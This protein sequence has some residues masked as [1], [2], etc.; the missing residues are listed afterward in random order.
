MRYIVLFLS[1]CSLLLAGCEDDYNYSAEFTE[2]QTLISPVP[3]QL[4]LASVQNVVFSWKGGGAADGGMLLYEVLFDKAGGDFSAPLYRTPSDLGGE[5]QLTL[6]HVTLNKLARMAGIKTGETGSLKWTVTASRGGVVKPAKTEGEIVLTR[7]EGLEVPEQLYLYG[8]ATEN[9]SEG[10]A[11]RLA[12]DGVFVVYTILKA[13]GEIYFAGD[14]T[15]NAVKYYI[16]EEGVLVEGT[17][18]TT[19]TKQEVPVRLTVNFNTKAMTIDTISAIR[20]IW[21][22]SYNTIA[23][24]TYTGNGV[25]KAEDVAVEFVDPSRPGTNPPDWL[26]WI[27]ERYYF[28]ATVNGA[29]VCWG[30]MDGVS[31]ERP[32]GGEPLSFYE[33]GEFP[34]SQW[35]H[36]WKMSGNLDQKRCTVTINT[37]IEG[38]MVHQ[39]S[40]VK[41]L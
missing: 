33:L 2:P 8:P 22:C 9:G 36:L 32:V 4:D 5:P 39:F 30:R 29:E 28:I 3:L 15:E 35:D 23:D 41:P 16:N 40:D 34:W 7:P 20:M 18:A 11:F 24:L 10:Q 26:S 25:F 31:S 13:D 38:L 17:S 6:T 12:T 19:V 21:G 1:V 37:N 14:Q 27:E